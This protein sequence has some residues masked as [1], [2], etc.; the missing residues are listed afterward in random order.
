MTTRSIDL[1]PAARLCAQYLD[2]KRPVLCAVSGGLDSMCLL[3][4]L[5]ASGYSVACAHF[6]HRLR[7]ADSARD[8]AFVRAWCAENGIPFHSSSGDVLAHARAA[9][10]SVEE[11]ARTLRYRFL[12]ETAA[13]LGAQLV[14]AHHQ[15]DNAETVLLNLIRGADVQGLRGM[16]PS[17]GGVVR[18][19]LDVPRAALIAYAAE[20]AIPHVED[21][22]NA[23]P[24]AAARN[25]LRHEILP[26]METL[27]PR[28]AEHIAA[29]A[30][31]LSALDDSIARE[32][33]ELLSRAGQAE[34]QAISLPLAALRGRSEAVCARVLLQMA[35][36]LGIGRKDLSRRQIK[37]ALALIARGDRASRS[38]SL[39]RGARLSVESGAL[40]L[41]RLPQ[42]PSCALAADI[43][44]R[45]GEYTLTRLSRPEGE[46]LALRAL[47]DGET[48][49]VRP[50]DAGAYLSLPGASGARSVRRL[51]RDRGISLAR[52]DA[53]PALYVG[54]ALAAVWPLGVDAAFCPPPAGD[55]TFVRIGEDRRADKKPNIKES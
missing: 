45:W 36:A 24:S 30:R 53:L 12:R 10:E 26:R 4:Y 23:D 54:G 27:N 31:S 47:F 46:G 13:A 28:A 22:T 21:A 32:A 6:D 55:L 8:A 48:L 42:L 38:L 50:C 25:Y 43:P 7:G 1:A 5:R 20:N 35:D 11:A 2:K 29:A 40:T 33:E 14:T 19:F 49:C 16:K 15:N 52:R 17:Q 44:L 39:P 41:A 18:P 9:G 34:Q 37:A 3:H 51:C